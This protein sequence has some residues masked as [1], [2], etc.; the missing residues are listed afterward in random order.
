MVH[1]LQLEA[2]SNIHI[3]QEA[4][5][6]MFIPLHSALISVLRTSLSHVHSFELDPALTQHKSS[7]IQPRLTR[8][9]HPFSNPPI[10]ANH[11]QKKEKKTGRPQPSLGPR[12]KTPRNAVQTHNVPDTKEKKMHLPDPSRPRSAT[13]LKSNQQ[14]ERKNATPSRLSKL[15]TPSRIS[16]PDAE[17]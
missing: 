5:E 1:T 17:T 3:P 10:Q 12:S 4:D 16:R 15:G 11:P 2:T 9:L 7:P 14:K 13:S 8:A 6:A